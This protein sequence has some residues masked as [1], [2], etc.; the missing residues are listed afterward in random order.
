VASTLPELYEAVASRLANLL[1]VDWGSIRGYFVEKRRPDRLLAVPRPRTVNLFVVIEAQGELVIRHEGGEDFTEFEVAGYRVPGIL[2][3]KVQSAERRALLRL[4]YSHYDR[5]KDLLI[6]AV[7]AAFEQWGGDALPVTGTEKVIAKLQAGWRCYMAPKKGKKEKEEVVEPYC[8]FCPNCMI[9]GYAGLEEAGSYNV[10]SRVE[11]DVFY[12]LC[13]SSS[14]VVQ[15]TFNAVDDV[16]KTTFYSG[17]ETGALY[18][19]SLIEPGTVF[20]GKITVRDPSPAE[21]LA[22]MLAVAHVERI[23][24]RVTH[25][26][27]VKT[28]IPAVVLSGFERG[29]GYELASIVL[30]K[31]EGAKAGLEEAVNEVTEYARRVATDS[32]AVIAR[33]DLADQLRSMS[34]SD[35]DAV[36]TAA[37]LDGLAF[38]SSIELSLSQSK[39]R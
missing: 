1:G 27:R 38:K 25:F 17:G 9:Y 10:K 36:L 20:V 11:G 35:I 4:L 12:G 31:K 23:G 26:G 32:D 29:T 5:N 3:T 21:L 14:C 39:R 34:T 33:R 22:V 6:E 24:A 7:K 37:W 16:T 19:L 8:G 2:N 13:P 18:Q 28:Y 30:R 15:R